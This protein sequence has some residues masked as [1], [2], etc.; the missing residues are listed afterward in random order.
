MKY[1]S[2]QPGL[3][4]WQDTDGKKI[5]AHGFSVIWDENEKKYY[6]YGENKE[7]SKK[8]GH[9]WT[10]GI[11][12]YSSED[13]YNWKD[14]GFIIPPETDPFSPL[15]PGKCL[16]R[17]HIIYCAKTKKYVAWLKIMSGGENSQYM[18]IMQSDSFK[19][20][21]EFVNKC[22]KPLQMDSGDFDLY[23]DEETGKGYYWF[24]RPH[25][26]MICATLNEEF[27]GVTGEFSI[28]FPDILPPYTREAPTHFMRNGKHYLFTSGT[29]GYYP[30][31][32]KVAVFDDYHG[33]Y[34]DLGDPCI[35]D[36]AENTFCAQIT[37]VIKI[38]GKKDL[39]VAVADRWKPGHNSKI[40]TMSTQKV[41]E[42]MFK[43]YQ[44]DRTP[45]P[46]GTLLDSSEDKHTD[47]TYKSTYVWLPIEWEGDKP[48]LRWHKEWKLENYN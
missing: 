21:Y 18:T 9:I 13:F 45:K 11:R 42:K 10:Y 2:I 16:D 39:Y 28:H 36:K 35:G 12:L 31:K 26:E 25:F 22:Y 27:T 46:E 48:V 20:P 1:N 41:M 19:G 14:E 17:P 7:F 15:E 43:N 33:E 5:Q 44:P 24:E 3:K 8:G 23:V 47:D 32:T 6:W 29:S 38:P 40:M 37:D 34:T 30:N 4:E